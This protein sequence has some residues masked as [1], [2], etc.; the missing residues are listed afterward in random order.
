MM[1]TPHSLAF[2]A[3]PD[4]VSGRELTSFAVSMLA[5]TTWPTM[6]S[7][8]VG[9]V[10]VASDAAGRR[11]DSVLV[12]YWSMTQSVLWPPRTVR[13]GR[14]DGRIFSDTTV[15]KNGQLMGRVSFN[16]LM[17][18]SDESCVLA[19]VESFG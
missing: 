5:R 3:L 7:L 4:A 12:W 16:G 15:P 9:I 14:A 8:F 6:Y 2:F 19:V 10:G 11:G 17:K 1:L 18:R 13:P